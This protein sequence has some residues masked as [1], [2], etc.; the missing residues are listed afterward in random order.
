MVDSYRDLLV[1]QN[2]MD[3]VESCYRLT[4]HFPRDEAFGLTSQVR[5][6]ASSIPADIA[7]G[8]G[9]DSTGEYVQFVRVA[10]GSLKEVETHLLLA[11]RLNLCS[12]D[13]VEPILTSTDQLGRMLR[14][15]YRSL[16]EHG[17]RRLSG[18]SPK[19]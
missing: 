5:R 13:A 14:A 12:S 10:Q 4:A 19:D 17:R 2:G 6:A 9:R 3:L 8:Y 16:Q 11:A 15:L 7:E 1:R 18:G